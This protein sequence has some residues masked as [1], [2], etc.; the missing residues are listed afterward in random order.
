MEEQLDRVTGSPEFDT[1]QRSV[2]FL[3]FVVSEVL[4]G[5]SQ[6]ISQ[7]SIAGSVFGRGDEFD[8]TTDPIVRMQAGRVRRSIEH[9]Y[10]TAG[11]AD[12]VS[13]QLPKGSYVPTF[14]WRESYSGALQPIDSGDVPAT[15]P[16]PTLLVSPLRNLT[17]RP[18]VDFVA[19]G[20]ASDL[21][22]EFSRN[23]ALHVF[24]GPVAGERPGRPDEARFRLGGTIAGRNDGLKLTLDLI[25]GESGRQ[26]WAETFLCPEGPEQACRLEKVVHTT[27][28][29]VAEEQ[30]FLSRHLDGESRRDPAAGG[31]AYQA[32]LRYLHFDVTNDPAAFVEAF[33]ALRQAVE[34][35][36]E[37]A[38]C[39][40]YLARLG[41]AHWS[42]GLSGEIL[43]IEESLAAARRGVGLAPRDVRCRATLSYLLLLVDEL[44]E[45]LGEAEA[46][47]ELNGMSMFWLDVIGYLLSLSGD[48]KRGP[49]LLRQALAINPFPRRACYGA[50]W[51]EGLMREDPAVALTAAREY[52]P[53]AYFWSPLMESVAL[54]ADGQTE[55]AAVAAKRLLEMKPDFP[56]KG[57]WL[58]T[59]YVKPPELV[60]LIERSLA[61]AGL[62]RSGVT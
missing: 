1:S 54:S 14:E 3:R 47:L 17:G 8:P 12:P 21:A 25:D 49:T 50:L 2:D 6:M 39:W 48:W 30:G 40:S 38:V 31:G 35:D 16:W 13:I 62:R 61:E 5:R 45:A 10:L 57:H 7:Q 9:Y 56:E 60:E 27:V 20:L 55:E 46:A 37:C 29:M 4:D 15:D 42:L 24:R 34:A 43:P 52:A 22:A 23:Q 18:E 36:P 53:E 33:A 19:E 28:A 58:I 41:G 11:V 59:R 51:L 26:V 32:I 44:D